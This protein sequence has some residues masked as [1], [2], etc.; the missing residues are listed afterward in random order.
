M[1]AT[2]T[3]RAEPQNRTPSRHARAQRPRAR[4]GA[5]SKPAARRRS[6]RIRTLPSER[7]R[8]V[9]N[10]RC[11]RT[12]SPN[13]VAR[14][15]ANQRARSATDRS[16]VHP[17]RLSKP[18]TRSPDAPVA[19][20]NSGAERT[21]QSLAAARWTAAALPATELPAR[22]LRATEL[23][24]KGPPVSNP[25]VKTRPMDRLPT[26]R[27]V[28]S[29]ISSLNVRSSNVRPSKRTGRA[30]GRGTTTVVQSYAFH[31]VRPPSK[32]LDHSEGRKSARQVA[33]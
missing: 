10:R 8:S 13:G 27:R 14:R 28:S 17:A 23:P 12:E 32:V 18:A 6:A 33:K 15:T 3:N 5:I 16:P 4:Q 24:A 26:G 19:G 21:A 1:N 31:V 29:S 25:T 9:S 2:E 11:P 7:R 20:A 30:V 22:E